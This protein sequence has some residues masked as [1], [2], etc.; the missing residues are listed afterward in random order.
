MPLAAQSMSAARLAAA[1]GAELGLVNTA[2]RRL[3]DAGHVH[4]SGEWP[5]YTWRVGAQASTAE[6]VRT[7]LRLIAECPM[8]VTELQAATDVPLLRVGRVVAA[9]R[10]ATSFRDRLLDMSNDHTGTWFLSPPT[11]SSGGAPEGA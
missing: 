9:I 3:V 11:T 6:L 1:L 2:L 5:T 4:V 7:V 8:T 10:C